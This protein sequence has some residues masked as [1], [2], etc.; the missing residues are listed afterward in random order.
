MRA[1]E[2][3]AE[4]RSTPAHEFETAHPGLVAPDGNG[5]I[6]WGRYYD[7]YRVSSL[8]GMDPKDLKNIDEIGF[9]GNLPL[10]S[11][12]TQ[13]DHDKLV[14]ILK[15]LGL[16]PKDYIRQGSRE[17]NGIN[18]TSPMRSFRGYAR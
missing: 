13:H 15:R 3:I 17:T 6:Y 9:F 1:R 7:F 2:F 5:D 18:T 4:N 12:Y 16:K 8:A 11:A 14:A 10:F